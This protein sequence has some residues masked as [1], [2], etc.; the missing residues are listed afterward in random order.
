MQSN[1]DDALRNIRQTDVPSSTFDKVDNVL[2]SLDD[3]KDKKHIKPIYTKPVIAAA[4]I[5]M[6][7]V[8]F[9][10]TA[11]AVTGIIDFASIFRVGLDNETV[12]PYIITGEDIV[13][14]ANE[15]KLD[16]QLLAAFI[17]DTEGGGLY[18]KFE[19]HDP[20]G[21]IHSDSF[22]LIL[23]N[24]EKVYTGLN[25]NIPA[26]MRQWLNTEMPHSPDDVQIIDANTVQAGFFLPHWA[27]YSRGL[28]G[29]VT[30]RFDF[31][32]A[33]IRNT[34]VDSGFNIGEH[35]NM[36]GSVT[37][38]GAEF[39][40]I[41]GVELNGSELTIFYSETLADPMVYGWGSGTLSL[42]KSSGETISL[43]GQRNHFLSDDSF[44]IVGVES[45]FYIGNTDP[46]E[47]TLIWRGDMA[48]YIFP[49]RWVFIIDGNT[50]MQQ[51]F[52]HGYYQGHRMEVTI[53]A[54]SVNILIVDDDWI[55]WDFISGLFNEDSLVLYMSDG[56]VVLP[57]I[58]GADGGNLTYEIEFIDPVDIKRVT[59]RGVDIGWD[60]TRTSFRDAAYGG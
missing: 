30:V 4:A 29:K 60:V 58:G 51:G 12:A 15:S 2:R 53:S 6:T 14:H 27:E 16:I 45:Y 50:S 34:T 47:L 19:I 39:V 46:G 57:K 59:F 22:V 21:E 32:A 52:F 7:L 35:L 37:L 42:M 33:G 41:T 10:T 25:M 48:E 9:T 24:E 5:A 36:D 13:I 43:S 38:T 54:T 1:I 49:G 3:R 18:L 56:T 26:D 20:A 44:S 31:I 28:S 23:H 55:D 17:D 11:L 40:Q 8:I